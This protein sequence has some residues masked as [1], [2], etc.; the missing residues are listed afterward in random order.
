MCAVAVIVQPGQAITDTILRISWL[1]FLLCRIRLFCGNRQL[2]TVF[3]PKFAGRS[4]PGSTMKGTA[5]V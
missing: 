2:S 1:T 4:A 3:E 5:N